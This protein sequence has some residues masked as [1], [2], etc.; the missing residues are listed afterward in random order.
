MNLTNNK[1]KGFTLV[2]LAIVLVIVGLLISA[3]LVPL[4]AQIDQNKNAQARR[5]L[6]EI[7]EAL[8]GFVTVNFK[9]PCPDTNGD[10]IDDGC[11]NTN[12]NTSTGGNLPW[13]DL[14]LKSVDP[15]GQAYQYRV[16]NAFST[17]F[18][19]TT[20]G[21][22]PGIIEVCK[23]STCLVKEATNVPVL[24]FSLGKNGAVS[25][26]TSLDEQENANGNGRFVNHEFSNGANA[27]DDLLTWIPTNLI[28]NRMIT[29]GKLP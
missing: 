11:A 12:A 8:L 19:L 15:W 27:F 4:S 1:S 26:P 7:K 21:S 22:A 10:G 9:L 2:E 20:L 3:F 5:D 17:N 16:N 24:I 28:M 6:Q 23:S 18:I 29:V 25:P 13:A 14:G